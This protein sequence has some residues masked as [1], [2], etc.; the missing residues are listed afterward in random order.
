MTLPTVDEVLAIPEVRAGRPLVLAGQGRLD[1]RVRWVHVSELEDASGLL[2]GSELILT[3]GIALPD[4]PA[5]FAPTSKRW[6]PPAPV[7]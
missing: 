4:D 7:H 1:R 2:R 5:R 3:T 6:W